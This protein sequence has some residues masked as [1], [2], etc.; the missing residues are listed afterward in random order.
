MLF[1]AGDQEHGYADESED[2]GNGQHGPHALLAEDE[3]FDNQREDGQRSRK[4]GDDAGG[5]VFLRPEERA[6]LGDEHEKRHD[7]QASPL[8]ESRL[9]LALKAHEGVEQDAGGEEAGSG[10]EE[11]RQF[12][13]GDA[14]GEERG[15]PDHVDS[16]EREDH[17]N[18]GTIQIL[19]L[20]RGW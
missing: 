16:E 11:G 18:A 14:D 9:G 3:H 20:Q 7:R 19:C 15:A 2:G 13:N 5:D 10:G 8:R 1:A 17:A 6:I 12:F 4:H